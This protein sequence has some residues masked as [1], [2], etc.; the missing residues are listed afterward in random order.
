MTKPNGRQ[1][2]KAQPAE[3]T[4]D[5]AAEEVGQLVEAAMDEFLNALDERDHQAPR[6]A[7]DEM[8]RRWHLEN[9]LA[10]ILDEARDYLSVLTA[11]ATKARGSYE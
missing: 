4:A 5:A 11:E 7:V 8:R 1:R 2:K 10:A 3:V 9:R 6:D